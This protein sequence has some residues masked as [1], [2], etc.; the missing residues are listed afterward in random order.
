MFALSETNLRKLF[1]FFFRLNSKLV[2]LEA[3]D[4]FEKIFGESKGKSIQEF[5]AFQIFSLSTGNELHQLSSSKDLKA[6]SVGLQSVLEF[7][8]EIITDKNTNE[9]LVLLFPENE[10]VLRLV[11]LGLTENDFSSDF[12]QL[13]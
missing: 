6:Q 3:G 1:P 4:V 12:S 7:K 10:S 11:K 13:Q 9:I 5:I 8:V 2:I